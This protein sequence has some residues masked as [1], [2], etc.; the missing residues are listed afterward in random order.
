MP[1]DELVVIV[2]TLGAGTWLLRPVV[3]AFAE[4]LRGPRLA[5]AEAQ[6][7]IDALREE[8]QLTRREVADLGERLDFAERL[9]ASEREA[10]RLPRNGG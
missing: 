10:Q 8:V 6:H 9:L 5:D 2:G 1:L 4:R 3:L 7:Q